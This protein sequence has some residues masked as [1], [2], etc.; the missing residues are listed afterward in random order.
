[1]SIVL[2]EERRGRREREQKGRM[3]LGMQGFV[4]QTIDMYRRGFDAR[5]MLLQVGLVNLIMPYLTRANIRGT[6]PMNAEACSNVLM[7][8]ELCGKLYLYPSD[9]VCIA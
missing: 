5:R 1:M 2:Q 9:T 8:A 4:A 7:Q 3:E 6:L